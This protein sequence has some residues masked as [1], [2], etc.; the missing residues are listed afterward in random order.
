M[1][2]IMLTI[3]DDPLRRII[4]WIIEGISDIF[5]NIQNV[6]RV[7]LELVSGPRAADICGF[8]FMDLYQL[9]VWY[10]I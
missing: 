3:L 2:L 8:D 9:P 6:C 5:Q 1:L 4:I 7:H 10:V